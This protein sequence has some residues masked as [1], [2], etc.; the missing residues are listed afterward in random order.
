VDE[1]QQRELEPPPT[2]PVGVNLVDQAE[3]L[4]RT[5]DMVLIDCPPRDAG[6]MLDALR[7]CDIAIVPVR[8]SQVDLDVLGDTLDAVDHAGVSAYLH[9][10][11]YDAR[12]KEHRDVLASLQA[13]DI[14]ML[15][16]ITRYLTAFP[17]AYRARVGVG[18]YEP[19]GAAADDV[20]GLTDELLYLL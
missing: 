9:V 15:K 17:S 5:V 7:V 1:A 13:S 16:S 14:P 19:K 12:T 11:N 8:A 20:R 18:R 4:R 3:T 2:V 10:T 6:I